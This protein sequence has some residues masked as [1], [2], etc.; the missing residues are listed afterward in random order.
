[1]LKNSTSPLQ[2]P[3]HTLQVNNPN[4][5]RAKLIAV[6]LLTGLSAISFNALSAE[7]AS[8]AT[9]ALRSEIPESVAGQYLVR[10]KPS[11][12]AEQIAEMIFDKT[13]STKND[14]EPISQLRALG[15]EVLSAT[16]PDTLLVRSL[17]PE[18]GINLV[19]M[20]HQ[21]AALRDISGTDTVEP[22][23]IY[24]AFK[25]P[26]DS[27][28]EKLWGLTNSGTKD[29]SGRKGMAG[30]DIN[31]IRAWDIETGD[32]KTVV[33][34]IDTG[35][36]FAHP[37]LSPN[38]WVNLAELNGKAGVD[39]D[40]NGYIDDI[41][42]YNAIEKNGKSKDDN[43]HGS[44]CSGTIGAAG[45]NQTGIAGINWNVSLMASKF[46]DKDGSGDLDS[47]IRAIDYA[48]KNGAKI[49]SNSWGGGGRSEILFKTIKD[50]RDAGIL[51]VAAA[52]N[53]ASN[54][55]AVDSYP[56]NYEA[57][58]IISV[59]AVDNRGGLASFSNYGAKKVHIGAP[60]V[61]IVS[62][63][64]AGG[65]DSY[66]GTSMAAPHV[67]GVA[68]L[69]LSHEPSL[70]YQ[71]LKARILAGAKPL[72]S[73][74]GKVATAGLLDAYNSLT[75][76]APPLT[77]PNDPQAWSGKQSETI[78]SPHPYPMKYTSQWTVKVPGA[79]RIAIQFA[80]FETEKSYDQLYFFNAAGES[81]GATSG[82]QTGEFSPVVD[83]DTVV[84]KFKADET[85][86]GYGFDIVSVV[87]E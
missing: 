36:D 85:V 46:L 77:D 4:P 7:A 18:K 53:D 33:A 54:N 5:H 10:F 48:R 68:A 72:A 1:V 73:L 2:S 69:L 6:A 26:N 15:F 3:L 57:D 32:K 60:G 39:D 47:A 49:M 20:S 24:R 30:V 51:F 65:Y 40:G 58:N 70:T 16:R 59:A 61:N 43:G 22:N 67:A 76:T 63:V 8:G 83:G 31:A 62:T 21:I 87:Y 25:N 9:M 14:S 42:G 78:S 86:N 74:R 75:Q 34:V 29:T 27:D 56:A 37:E 50:A 41:N 55:D 11:T 23:F 35:I 66:S 12:A 52:G 19:S 38:A 84:L 71:N 79:K 64:L 81:F 28:F 45:D 44:H 13:L 17:T 82:K 80:K